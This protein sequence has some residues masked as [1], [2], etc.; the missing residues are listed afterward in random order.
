MKNT[1]PAARA[2]NTS[3]AA[4]TREARVLAVLLGEADAAEQAAVNAL[5]AADPALH[6]W[7][8]QAAAILPALLEALRL[9]TPNTA[10]LRMD[11]PRRA[12]LLQ[13]LGT[14]PP[15]AAN[16]P[17][18]HTAPASVAP[19]ASSRPASSTVSRVLRPVSSA[20]KPAPPAANIISFRR[21]LFP[22]AGCA[23][24][25]LVF[26]AL[27]I[28]PFYITTLSNDEFVTGAGGNCSGGN[29]RITGEHRPSLLKGTGTLTL[30]T[31][32]GTSSGTGTAASGEAIMNSGSGRSASSYYGSV[33]LEKGVTVFLNDTTGDSHLGE[34]AS[35]SISNSG[36]SEK[37]GTL[38]LST[39][40]NNTEGSGIRTQ[41]SLSAGSLAA[42]NGTVTLS[43]SGSLGNSP[44]IGGN[45]S[46]SEHRTKP[47]DLARATKAPRL[48]S[49][50][51]AGVSLPEMPKMEMTLESGSSMGASTR[52]FGGGAGGG[53]G[54]G[55]GSGPNMPR[56]TV[57]LSAR[58]RNIVV[59]ADTDDAADGL[60][61]EQHPVTLHPA[62]P[63]PPASSVG[64]VHA[65]APAV[66]AA[67]PP[68]PEPLSPDAPAAAAPP[69]PPEPPAAL[70]APAAAA[71]PPLVRRAHVSTAQNPFSTFSLNVSDASFRLAAEALRQNRRP[72]SATLRTE[73][74][75]NAL[76]YND[77]PP[78]H[79]ETVA[80]VQEQARDPFSH[81][82]NFLRLSIVTASTGRG[83]D[84]PLNLT[85]LLDTSGSMERADRR[86][87]TDEALRALAENI[88]KTDS[89]GMLG[90]ARTPR[91]LFQSRGA[92]AANAVLAQIGA[93]TPEG[94]TNLELALDAAYS[95]NR[96]A[97]VPGALNRIVLLT[98]GAA[99]LGDANSGNLARLV[100]ENKRLGVTLDCFGVGFDDYNDAMLESLAR[101][102]NGR[103][104][105]RNNA[106][107]AREDFARKL[108]GALRVA[109]QN[110]KVQVEFNPARVLS[111]RLLGYEKHLLAKEQF[112]D[113]TVLA[114]QLGAAES[115]T[116]V[117][118]I[119]LNPEGVG[120]VGVVR[121]RYQDPR[122]GTYHERDWAI[123][124]DPIAAPLDATSVT[125]GASAASPSA[126]TAAP[127]AVA[128]SAATA[129]ASAPASAAAVV[130]AVPVT[131]AVPATSTAVPLVSVPP[132]GVRLAA[133]A[134]LFA[135]KLDGAEEAASIPWPALISII[136]SANVVLGDFPANRRLLEMAEQARRQE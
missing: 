20:P 31:D 19:A 104:A 9:A 11:A 105:Y 102:A 58:K 99:N 79:G 113:N 119:E 115:G 44:D 69:P 77:A 34:G 38:T 111:W 12:A 60:L 135:E 80:L 73:E 33:V 87:I 59:P 63:A 5:L 95:Q 40:N 17:A 1:I 94:G 45:V 81:S 37:N 15:A 103:Y 120:D 51:A 97:S 88:R 21:L 36:S 76:A 129:A 10:P 93:I 70:A 14:A 130:S 67:P 4:P 7:R 91:L 125:A 57:S 112:R 23:C 46:M 127:A 53:V 132:A 90:F 110:V 18:A 32:S 84:Q 96:A 16:T 49:K 42:A 25:A 48:T 116:A 56:S 131:S 39:D 108:A 41:G 30:S 62:A 89:V 13:K 83:A 8:D 35:G 6:L 117:Y 122:S 78:A 72:E 55:R 66:A 64:G 71:M 61:T 82:R 29:L 101:A 98:D 68:P 128:A 124:H 85:V 136:R 92:T 107:E 74:F 126:P 50:G 100:A 75:V 24:A 106:A 86:A 28:A 52:G 133:A 118:A 134:A 22:L 26:A 3:A 2:D 109:A 54:T 121:A 123:P 47:R 43:G 65:D 27:Y 114:A